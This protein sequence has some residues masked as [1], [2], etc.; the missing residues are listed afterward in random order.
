MLVVAERRIDPGRS[1][2]LAFAAVIALVVATAV[3][4]VVVRLGGPVEAVERAYDAFTGPPTP[5]SEDLR[6]RLFTFS[7]NYR[8]ELWE[9]SWNQYEDNLLLGG[10][11]GTYEQYW[12]QDRPIDHKVRDA[13]NLYL[14]TLGEL[15][16]VGLTLLLLV[17]GA[18]LAAAVGARGHPLAAGVFG[19]YIAYLVHAGVD[20]DWE[21]PAVTVA[22]LTCA[23]AL[24][25]LRA[26]PGS[27]RVPGIRLRIA[28]G[29]VAVFMAGAAFVGLVGASALAASDAAAAATPPNWSEAEDEARKAKRW[30]PWS[31]EPWQRLGEAQV[32]RG[33]LAGAR[34]SLRKA[35]EKEPEDWL[36]WFRLAEASSGA[37]REEAL[38][39]AQRL[40]PLSSEIRELRGEE[41][42]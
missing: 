38:D 23:A 40:N 11:A 39:R 5:Q 34:A 3:L 21:L 25:I 27:A 22:A 29:V 32:G 7:G 1:L 24:L 19:A 18:P 26:P 9:S 42:P 8:I 28:I 30:A 12:N 33:D 35:I 4:G 6:E 37:D 15:G 2:R 16:P 17:L 20:W 36:L 13:H 10:G 31:S 41:S 14:E